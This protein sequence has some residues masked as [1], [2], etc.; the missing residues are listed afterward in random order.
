M[1]IGFLLI[2]TKK[3]YVLHKEFAE[4]AISILVSLVHVFMTD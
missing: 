1:K 2:G 4:S 3:S